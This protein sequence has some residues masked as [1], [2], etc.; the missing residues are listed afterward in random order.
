ML[1]SVH[2]FK[3]LTQTK[4]TLMNTQKQRAHNANGHKMP[5]VTHTN[6][7][8]MLHKTDANTTQKSSAFNGNIVRVQRKRNGNFHGPLL[9]K[10]PMTG[11]VI[12]ASDPCRPGAAG[13]TC[14]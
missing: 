8:Q 5:T 11:Y 7:T 12:V 14:K 3:N 13:D 4:Q 9:Y 1:R 6:P 2:E 10:G